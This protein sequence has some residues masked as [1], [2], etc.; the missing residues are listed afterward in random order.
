MFKWIRPLL[1][2]GLMGLAAGAAIAQEYPTKPITLI[3]PFAPG[4]SSDLISRLLGQKLTEAFKQQVIVDNRGG[5]AGFV[6]MQ[7]AARAA[8]DGYT[9]ILGHIGTLAVNPAMFAK[10]PY[11]VD[12]FAPVTLVAT[13]PNVLVV[14]PALPAKTFQEFIKLAKEKPGTLN[15][16]SAGI[17]SAGHLAMEYLKQ[18]TGI[19]M[20][21]VPYKGTGP[22]ITDLLSG[23]TQATFT[24]APPLMP[25]IKADKLRPLAVGSA[26]RLETL[27]DVPSVAE[28]DYPGFETSQW[29]GILAPAK[30]PAP[31]VQKLAAEI[32]RALQNPEVIERFQHDGSIPTASTPEEFAAFI[33]KEAKLW[34]DI[35]KA[36]GIQPN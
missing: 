32:H 36:A 12:E 23:Q 30:T 15:Y 6:G 20:S 27:P 1:T 34:G 2:V 4:G 26:K 8:P 24:G 31:I 35:V 19:E 21:H 29:Y 14:S 3:V 10:M 18:K 11:K 13:V 25:H 16:G 22:M 9:L 17:G 5:G 7:A 28:Q 33:E